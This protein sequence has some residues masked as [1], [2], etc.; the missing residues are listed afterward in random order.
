MIVIDSS[1][2]GI[3]P[4]FGNIL[5]EIALSFPISKPRLV[6]SLDRFDEAVRRRERDLRQ[7]GDVY[8]HPSAILVCLPVSTWATV[9]SDADLL[10]FE[11]VA[12]RAAHHRF[13]TAI[14][15][16][17]YDR[18]HRN[19]LVLSASNAITLADTDATA[20]QSGRDKSQT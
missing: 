8:V 5:D 9:E 1:Q 19:L 16:G 12:I 7:E 6:T 11:A 13:A 20:E 4:T 18:Q 14:V 15:G 17:P 10:P 3:V 2:P